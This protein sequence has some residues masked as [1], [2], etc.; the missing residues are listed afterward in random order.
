MTHP[1]LVCARPHTDN[2]Q[3][4][5]VILKIPETIKTFNFTLLT[6]ISIRL[7]WLKG[8]EC[9]GQD[10]IEQRSIPNYKTM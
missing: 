4:K 1:L 3:F 7:S 10:Y 2:W 8:N 9:C 5:N 6:G